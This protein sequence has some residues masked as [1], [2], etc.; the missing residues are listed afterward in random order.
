MTTTKALEI[1]Q[2]ITVLKHLAGGKPIDVTATITGLTAETVLDLASHHGYPDRDKLAWAVDVLTKKHADTVRCGIPAATARPGP[3]R[4]APVAAVPTHPE[5]REQPSSRLADLVD[6]ALAHPSKRIRTAA[7][8]L[9]D[10]A[11]KLRDLIRED[12][13]KNAARRKIEAEKAAA[14]AEVERLQEQLA[15]AKAKLRGQAP[16][17]ARSKKGRPLPKGEHPCRHDGCDRVY[18]TPQGRSLHERMKCEHRPAE[19][20]S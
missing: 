8:R 18:D 1:P 14:R 20:A 4:P 11:D 10:Q 19:E 17:A 5:K 9:L 16:A 2:R 12:D 6:T 3:P 15:A 13:Q 7:D